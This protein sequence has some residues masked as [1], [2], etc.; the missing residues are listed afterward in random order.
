MG[1]RLVAFSGIPG[2]GKSTLA[3]E[4]ARLLGVPVWA[5]DELEAALRRRGL[6]DGV[7]G[8]E[9][10]ATVVTTELGAGRDVVCDSVLAQG[11]IR[12]RLRDLADR[13]DARFL[14]VECRLDDLAVLRARAEGRVRGIDGWYELTWQHVLNTVERY[15]PWHGERLVVDAS[16]PL[17]ENVARLA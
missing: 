8:Y 10:L 3:S 11:W 12:E 2:T 15:E 17:A 9:L 4:A 6:P 16:R 1:G 7:A 5:K 14:P 13:F